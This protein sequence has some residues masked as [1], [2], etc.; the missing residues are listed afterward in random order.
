MDEA[1]VAHLL[2]YVKSLA[3]AALAVPL[4]DALKLVEEIE[5]L[6]QAVGRGRGSPSGDEPGSL[7]L[8]QAF[9]AFRTLVDGLVQAE[10]LREMGL[11]EGDGLPDG[12]IRMRVI[13][14]PAVRKKGGEP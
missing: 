14:A 12:V 3:L 5:R 7:Q 2:N 8:A 9:L 13:P 4:G 6:A 1:T 10:P 11:G